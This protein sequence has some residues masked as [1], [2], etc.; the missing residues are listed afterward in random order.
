MRLPPICNRY[1]Q[2]GLLD[3][4]LQIHGESF[5]DKMAG[6]FSFAEPVPI[7]DRHRGRIATPADFRMTLRDIAQPLRSFP[8]FR[9]QPKSQRRPVHLA[10]RAWCSRPPGLPRHPRAVH[11]AG[12]PRSSARARAQDLATT[13]AR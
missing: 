12:R 11:H 9:L 8:L 5:A 10:A 3:V 4:V 1:G 13:P 6:L 2:G 7:G